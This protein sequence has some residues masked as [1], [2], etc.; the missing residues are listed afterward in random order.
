MY[1]RVFEKLKYT[2]N[3]AGLLEQAFTHSSYAHERSPDS[4]EHNER[5]EFLGD[6]VLEV[7]I[8]ELLY[9]RFPDYD[10]GQLTKFRAGLVCEAS[11]AKAG[12]E[13][14]IE[15]YLRL[16][17]GEESTGGRHR[18][19]L[20]ADAM[21]AVVGALFL[22]GGLERAR[23][24]IHD[25]FDGEIRRQSDS[26]EQFDNKTFL[27]E[28]FQKNSKIP[29]NYVITDESGPD[30]NKR[31]TAKVRH[32]GKIL[33]AGSGRSKKEAEQNAAAE[34]VKKLGLR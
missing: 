24:F 17:R 16:G 13:T 11:L 2:F 25:C 29:L 1:E 3:D 15:E 9:K 7:L 21:E 28:S 22:D 20:L 14:G 26:L 31:F 18:D 30:H 8:S 34:A 19:A 4:P 10:E 6:A 5:L 33:G 32:N 23:A 12:H 27:Q